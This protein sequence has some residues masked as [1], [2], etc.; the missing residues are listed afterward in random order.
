MMDKKIVLVTG[1]SS[2]IG[3][4]TAKELI[5]HGHVVYGAARRIDK[6]QALVD[7]GGHSLKM[8]VSDH[9]SV[10]TGVQ[11][12]IKEQG[13]IDVL[14]NNAGYAIY[15][16]IEDV[17]ID[18]ARR[19]FEVNLFGLADL[20]KQV[21]PIMREQESG[22]IINT[23]SIGGK[24]YSPLGSW[25][26]ATKHALEGWSDC[27]R[28]EVK[29]F[30][31]DVVILEPGAIITEFYDVMLDPMIERS[32]NGPYQTMAEGMLKANQDIHSK[33]DTSTSPAVIAK[34]VLKIV[35]ARKPKTRYATGKFAKPMLFARKW[36]SDRMFDSILAS[37][38][39]Y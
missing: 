5:K 32:K 18:E 20:T 3:F 7:T 33:P 2:G 30:G 21:I 19:Q 29:Q 6:M 37:M 27:L 38:T 31:I 22:L 23:S 13:R 17:S 14:W 1:A 24:I 15:G 10:V 11:Q 9:E 26:H 28:L 34:T 4:E 16:S 36:L 8:D 12:I 39:K 25:Y 35:N